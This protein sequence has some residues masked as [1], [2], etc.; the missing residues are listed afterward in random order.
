M[1]YREF[2]CF[3]KMSPTYSLHCISFLGLLLKILNISFVKLK[4][5][6]RTTMETIGNPLTS[7]RRMLVASQSA[8]TAVVYAAVRSQDR[9]RSEFEV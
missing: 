5:K 6:N 1:G 8:D 4:P 9:L 3:E 7:L 2:C